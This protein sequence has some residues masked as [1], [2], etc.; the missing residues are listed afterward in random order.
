ML[1]FKSNSISGADAKNT[2]NRPLRSVRIHSACLF[3]L[4]GFLVFVLHRARL[5]WVLC[6]S[7]LLLLVAGHLHPP[8]SRAI[9]KLS[10]KISTRVASVLAWIVLAPFYL[11]FFSAGHAA[12]ALRGRDPLRL[13]FPSDASTDW[14]PVS[15]A[16]GDGNET[17]KSPY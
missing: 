3:C 17:Y 7:G 8:L 13:K 6:G 15:S 14:L 16:T 2:V 12:L 4:G 11:L 1:K 5:G 10:G 9:E